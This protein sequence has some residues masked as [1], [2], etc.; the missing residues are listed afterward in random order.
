MI[1]QYRLDQ[2]MDGNLL[3][4]GFFMKPVKHILFQDDS[5]S[6][7]VTVTFHPTVSPS[8]LLPGDLMPFRDKLKQDPERGVLGMDNPLV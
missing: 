2:P 3:I 8:D 5:L 4:P 7:I 6:H 1:G